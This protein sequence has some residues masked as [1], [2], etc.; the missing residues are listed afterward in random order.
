MRAVDNCKSIL[1]IEYEHDWSVSLG[2]T[3]RD[4]LKIKKNIIIVTRIFP[5]KTD[6]AILLR[7]EFKLNPQ[8]LIKIVGA[9]FGKMKI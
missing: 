1:N 4:R 6:S 9:I 5:G 7:F 3:L 8:N 2:A